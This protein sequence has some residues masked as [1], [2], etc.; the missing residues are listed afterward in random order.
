MSQGTNEE[1]ENPSEDAV[2]QTEAQSL[3]TMSIQEHA[4]LVQSIMQNFP[5]IY[6]EAGTGS[7]PQPGGPTSVIPPIQGAATA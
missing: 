2:L 5:E 6:E 4:A 3:R 1:P 7:A